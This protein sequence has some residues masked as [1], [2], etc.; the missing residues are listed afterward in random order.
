[1]CRWL[2]YMGNPQSMWDI[3]FQS[4]HSIVVQSLT[5]TEGRNLPMVTVLVSGGILP[6]LLNPRCIGPWNRHGM[7]KT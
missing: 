5:A 2:A 1:M 7:T 4:K 6:A 3:L